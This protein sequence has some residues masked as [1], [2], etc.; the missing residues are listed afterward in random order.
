[1]S[2]WSTIKSHLEH[3][4]PPTPYLIGWLIVYLRHGKRTAVYDVKNVHS[5]AWRR[6]AYDYEGED[7]F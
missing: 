6:F 3:P 1:M 2:I 7:W 5:I 4:R